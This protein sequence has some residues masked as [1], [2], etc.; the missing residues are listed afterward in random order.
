MTSTLRQ[1]DCS[2]QEQLG[3]PYDVL[4]EPILWR[5]VT[6]YNGGLHAWFQKFLLLLARTLNNLDLE[7]WRQEVWDDQHLQAQGM[8]RR[9]RQPQHWWVLAST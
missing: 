4:Q 9:C 1:F 8:G 3:C 6:S 5:N 2:G 7:G